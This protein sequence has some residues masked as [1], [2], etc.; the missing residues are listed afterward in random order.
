MPLESGRGFPGDP[1]A[2]H[3]R[4]DE[5]VGEVARMG[6]GLQMWLQTMWFLTRARDASTLI[7]DEPDV[8][9]HADLQRRLIRHLKIEGRQVI[10]ATH[11]VEIMSEVDP[12]QIL[13]IER[14][15]RESRFADS[16]PA[17]QDLVERVGSA[18]NLHLARLWNARRFLMIEGD[19]LKI[20]RHLHDTIF[21]AAALSLESI[22]NMSIGGWGGWSWAIGSSLAL[23]NAFGEKLTSYCILDRDFHSDAE[24][25]ERYD[26]AAKMGVELHVWKRK[27]LE[28]YLLNSAAIA[29]FIGQRVSGAGPTSSGV[30]EMIQNLAESL[31]DEA[32]DALATEILARDHSLGVGGANKKARQ[33]VHQRESED[34]HLMHVVSGKRILRKISAWAHED[35]RVSINV[36][37]LAREL[38]RDEIPHEIEIVLRS[39]EDGNRF[40]IDWPK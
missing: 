2:L 36:L 6:H 14:K 23:R 38:S 10:I 1:L 5:F 32:L 29:R 17:V 25:K 19:D 27:E 16:I 7:L 18:H 20:L 8:Y 28:N 30:F 33:I 37:G 22:P 31:R 3:V 12:D 11:S 24:I 26:Q 15:R 35:F 34:G 4:N 21:P 40:E 13:I 39:V 9:M